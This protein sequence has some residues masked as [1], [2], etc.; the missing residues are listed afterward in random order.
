ME[1]PTTSSAE[2][3]ARFEVL[4]LGRS[5]EE[6]AQLPGPVRLTVTCS[7]RLGPDRSVEVASRLRA[8]GHAVT[9]HIAARMVRDRAH[10]D[11]LLAA[12]ADVGADDLFLIGGDADPQ[13]EYSSA[14][15]L[16]P[17]VSEHRQR[18][19]A[20]GIAG[21]PEGHPLVR[22]DQLDEAL[23][24]KSTLADYVVTQLCFDP[25]ALRNWIVQQREREM[26]LPVLIGIPG[27]VARKRLL[28]MSLR[29]GV[30]PSLTFLRKQRGLRSLFT[31]STADRLYDELVP[32]LNDPRLNIAGFHYYTFNQLINT[33]NW[34]H[35]KQD[36]RTD[37]NP[38]DSG[39]ATGYVQCEERTT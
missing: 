19:P 29:V 26:S 12:M 2:D 5:E 13:G 32:S 37:R 10:L 8:L 4:P 16:L 22:P 33:W 30:G 11:S 34:Q 14:V 25:E 39:A 35:E 7:P 9:V 27:K 17:I 24:E 6:A 31:G 15:Q 23:R 28:E 38:Q 20:I 21:Y 3:R 1:K 36:K 18:P